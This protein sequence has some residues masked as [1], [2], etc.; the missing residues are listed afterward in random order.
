MQKIVAI[1]GEEYTTIF[2]GELEN[3]TDSS[4]ESRG[5]TLRNSVTEMPEQVAH[6]IG[7]IVVKQKLH[8]EAG[9]I[10][11]ATNRSISPR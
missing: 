7:H 8:T 9:D 10:C 4:G 11:R 2:M 5:R 6:V 3:G 1:A